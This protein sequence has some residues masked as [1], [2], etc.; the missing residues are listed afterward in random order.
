MQT[1][2]LS[3]S[4][5]VI[6][7][8]CIIVSCTTKKNTFVTRTYHNL[9]S[10]YNA[11][12][13]GKE[14][15]KEG[16]RKVNGSFVDNYTNVLLMFKY[17]DENNAKSVYPQMDKALKKGS[18]VIKRHSI[19]VK[20]KRK[21]GVKRTTKQKAFYEKPEFCN[22]V[23]DSYLL[24]GKAHFY[25]HDFI[26]AREA[27]EY[28]ISRF[29]KELIRFDAMVWLIRTNNEMENFD[30][31]GELL[32]QIEGEDECPNRLKGEIGAVYADFYLKQ[33]KYKDAV[34]KL[35][36]AI[37]KAGRKEDKARYKFILAQIHQYLEQHAK[38]ARL[39]SEVIRLNPPYEMA[40]N[41]KIKRAG[42]FDVNQGDSK[43]IRKQLRKMLKDDKNIE[44][45]DQIYYAFGN[46]DFKEGA[47]EGAIK[48][49]KLSVES[50]VSNTNQRALSYL[51]LADIYFEKLKY[52]L[53]QAYYDSSI[54]FLDKE[55]PDYEKIALKTKNLT[56][57]V[58]HLNIVEMEDSLQMVAG[59]TESERNQFIDEIIKKVKE[60]ERRSQIEEQERRMNS[61][62]F[63][64]SNQYGNKS[65]T[66]TSGGK[67][68]FY[69]PTA[70]SF[71]RAEFE[72]KWGKRTLEDNWRRKNKAVVIIA[73]FDEEGEGELTDSVQT[74]PADNKTRKYYMA[75]LPLNDS[76]I[77]ISH[78]NIRDALFHA[79]RVYKDL[80]KDFIKAI[81]TFE[82][83]CSRYPDNEYLLSC[84]YELYLTNKLIENHSRA[85]YYKDLI[86]TK[87]PDSKYAKILTDPNY[88]QA[89]ESNKEK[90]EQLYSETYDHYINSDFYKVIENYTFA[91]SVYRERKIMPKFM[92]LN[93]ISIGRIKGVI[94]LAQSLKDLT[95][96]YP[97]S[98]IKIWADNI[99]ENIK[100]GN[101]GDLL[102]IS[103][104]T[105]NTS[106]SDL[107]KAKLSNILDEGTEEIDTE[108]EEIYLFD[109]ETIHFY[110][111]ILQNKDVNVN[112][113]RFNI[114]DFNIE[115]FSMIDFNVSSPV[116][117]SKDFQMITVKALENKEKA[118]KYFDSVKVNEK[119]YKDMKETDYRH[120]IISADNYPVFFNDKDITK[121]LKFFKKY[122]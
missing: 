31:S 60:E 68:Y 90:A 98:E 21:Q 108:E 45:Q 19:T 106:Q 1:R 84:Y 80:L 79:G 7:L 75:D 91:D 2:Y 74:K 30:K 17:G 26:P 41:A 85:E 64:Q 101:Y 24:L 13:N 86:I 73:E 82:E 56:Q 83:L 16:V 23:D 115:Y 34:T 11:Y 8:S 109:E 35:E 119:V 95:V 112:R 120:F 3:Y 42:S 38:A 37:D 103:Y 93:A 96:K 18:K 53:A 70:M 72:R 59:M 113:L 76:L 46:I 36:T 121:Y 100:R 47:V 110:I 87:Y 57:L 51:S 27:F 10:H 54:T 55:Y 122:Y 32:E 33:D 78:E 15:L 118:M 66:N 58:L 22:W 107:I 43:E 62:M 111:I 104:T 12:F 69:N 40:F 77:A 67:W 29:S 50:S 105:D 92:Y 89:M 20:P 117:L 5:S 88:L 48:N 114:S 63:N 39:F 49:Y 28:I 44:F 97:D 99:L 81:E 9:T 71:G 61:M 52:K 25:K 4:I 6:V 94:P 102:A 116:I 65:Q 14:S